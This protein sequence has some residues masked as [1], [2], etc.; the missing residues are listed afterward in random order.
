LRELKRL[1]REG[2]IELTCYALVEEDER[3]VRVSETSERAETIGLAAAEGM[4]RALIGHLFQAAGPASGAA[5]PLEPGDAALLVMADPRYA[6]CVAEELAPHGP[7]VRRPME[8]DETELALRIS[9]EQTMH[10]IGWLEEMLDH[11]ARKAGWTS[12]ADKEKVESAIRAGRTELG[13]ERGLLQSRLVALRAEL[14]ARVLEMTRR[15]ER[16]GARAAMALASGIMEAELDIADINE[17]LAL[18]I[19]DQLNG[20]ATRASELR[21]GSARAC[22]ETAAAVEDELHELEVRMRKYRAG[23][24]ATLASSASLAR[25]CV[26]RSRANAKLGKR[27]MEAAVQDHA[28]RLEQR[29]TLLKADIRRLQSEEPRTWN[30]LASKFREAWRGVRGSIDQAVRESR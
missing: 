25:Q 7:T 15:A 13:A 8:G 16:E 26:E 6:E 11:E 22:V 30:D 9:I 1:H 4:S 2:W 24:T 17:D 21:E 20:F 14:E 3:G 12:G 28:T 5:C 19:L 10:N 23:L 29:Y 18:C 27:G